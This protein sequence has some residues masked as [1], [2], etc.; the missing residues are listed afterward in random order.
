MRNENSRPFGT[1]QSLHWTDDPWT[2]KFERIPNT[3]YGDRI[4][5]HLKEVKEMK[6]L[7][8]GCGSGLITTGLAA[9]LKPA[10]IDAVDIEEYVDHAENKAACAARGY[11]YDKA[12]KLINYCVRRPLESLEPEFY[13]AIVSW[14]VIEHIPADIIDTELRIL[15]GALKD[16][17]VAI[18][19]SSPLYYSPFGSHVYK[20][21]PWFHLSLSEDISKRQIFS[22]A[23]DHDAAVS[24]IGCMKSLNRLTH[25]DFRSAVIRAGF[26]IKDEYTT[27]TS[28]TP[29]ARLSWIY[30]K[31]VLLTEQVVFTLTK[32]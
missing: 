16:N 14:S 2:E 6:L 5:D 11:D 25:H 8:F 30:N 17:G 22:L 28:L 1:E 19:Q 10:R 23:A 4:R 13:D 26:K 7:D 15:Y 27:T 29:P 3:Y 18:L 24:L 32:K 12:L 9:F 31:D 20:L 21:E